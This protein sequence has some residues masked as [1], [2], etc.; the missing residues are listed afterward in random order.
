M[1]C[2]GDGGSVLEVWARGEQ[3]SLWSRWVLLLVPTASSRDTRRVV[4][5]ATC[6][7]VDGL[8][9]TLV[10]RRWGYA[11]RSGGRAWPRSLPTACCTSCLLPPLPAGNAVYSLLIC[12]WGGQRPVAGVVAFRAELPQLRNQRRLWAEGAGVMGNMCSD[13][14]RG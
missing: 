7:R 4:C 8:A 9:T 10:V 12:A 5:A 1:V 2:E 6:V 14:G 13:S 11:P 3:A